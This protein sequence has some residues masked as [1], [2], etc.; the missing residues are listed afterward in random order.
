MFLQ[1]QCSPLQSQELVQP[2]APISSD[3][4]KK[5]KPKLKARISFSKAQVTHL[6]NPITKFKPLPQS[7]INLEQQSRRSTQNGNSSRLVTQKKEG[8]PSHLDFHHS[9][10]AFL[11]GLPQ[12]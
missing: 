12:G 1:Y 10:A 7:V 5:E 11:S 9:I 6:P 2:V 8:V 4:V 3:E